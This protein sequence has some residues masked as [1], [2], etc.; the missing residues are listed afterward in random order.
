[1]TDKTKEVLRLALEALEWS[2]EQGGGPEC[3]HES[4]G[5]VCFCKENK[6]ITAIQSALAEPEMTPAFRSSHA[7]TVGFQ[8][9][10]AQA[11]AEQPAQ[12][13]EPSVWT[14]TR[15]WNRKDTWTCPADIEKD[16]LDGRAMPAQRQEP[17]TLFESFQEFGEGWERLAWELCADENG[18]EACNDLIWEGGPI[19]EPWGD[20][21]LKY[22]DEAKRLIALVQ[23]HTSPPASKPWVGLTDEQ[24]LYMATDYYADDWAIR[25]AVQ[26]LND[27]EAKLRE[28]NA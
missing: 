2:V 9:G 4:G 20:R 23:K 27:H 6:A 7:Y 13:Q 12:Q 19:P 16:L 1:M 26:L 10:K 3:E 21:W 18:E 5:A 25:K 24:K 22:E 8:D 17:S 14:A 15:L 28:K 11:L